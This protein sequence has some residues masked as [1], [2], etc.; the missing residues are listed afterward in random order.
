[1]KKNY[2]QPDTIIVKLTTQSMI[3]I[4]PTGAPGMGGTTN[5]TSDL[6]SLDRSSDW[7]DED[8]W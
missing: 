3:A 7:D 8:D 1:M 4:S 5:N 2:N 6:L